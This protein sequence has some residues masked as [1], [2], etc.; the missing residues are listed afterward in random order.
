MSHYE[1]NNLHIEPECFHLSFCSPLA[2]W[3]YFSCVLLKHST[4]SRLLS[5]FWSIHKLTV[6]DTEILCWR[7]T[8]KNYKN[9][10]S[11]LNSD[12]NIAVPLNID[13]WIIYL[14]KG[15]IGKQDILNKG[16]SNI[17]L[18]KLLQFVQMFVLLSSVL[19]ESWRLAQNKCSTLM[20]LCSLCLQF[21][22][23]HYE[24]QLL[25]PSDAGI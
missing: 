4:W 5:A 1:W 17:R 3:G 8:W 25:K 13:N 20:F 9:G 19:P 16:E 18:I 11:G 10:R 22:L 12:Q 23:A 6:H 24:L 14:W 21:E 15:R 7:A 2:P